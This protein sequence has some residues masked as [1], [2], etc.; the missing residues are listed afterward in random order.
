MSKNYATWHVSLDVECPH[1]GEDV[2][3]LDDPEFLT[4]SDFEVAETRT[5]ATRD[6]EVTCPKCD[7]EF[8]VDFIY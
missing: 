2:D 6:V 5:D 3:L 7:K 1:C 8:I 4:G